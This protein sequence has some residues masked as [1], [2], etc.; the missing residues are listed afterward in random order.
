VTALYGSIQVAA[1]GIFAAVSNISSSFEDI[2][3]QFR[4]IAPAINKTLVLRNEMLK[5]Y[6]AAGINLQKVIVQSV[7]FNMSLAKTK[8]AFDA[9]YKSVGAKFIPTLTKQMDIFRQK[10]YQNMPNIQAALEK[11]VFFL[12]KA[13]DATVQLGSRVWSILQR[14]YDFFYDLHRRTDGWSTVII[15]IIAAWK[16]LNLSFLNTPIGRIIALGLAI[17]ALYDDFMTFKEGGE[18]LI[19]WGSDTTKMIVGLVASIVSVAGAVYAVITA[20]KAINGTVG[21]VKD[22]FSTVKTVIDGA[23]TAWAAFNFVLALNP[24]TLWIVAATVLLGLIG[25]LIW[26]WDLVKKSVLGFFSGLGDKM[27]NLIGAAPSLIQNLQNNPIASVVPLGSNV[28]N[29]PQTNQNV[30]QQT[31]INV[32]GVSDAQSVGKMV[33]GEQSRVNFDMVR[34]L[35]GATR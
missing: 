6:G 10:I 29:S 22:T 18:S 24:L 32:N 26:K 30:N 35:T 9:I 23:K 27:L 34:N 31:N 11:F 13:F 3:Y 4:I 8:F 5:A 28:A 16:L 12:L 14:I 21:I 1:A 20:I 25:L 7:K 15:G 2:G 17:V 19:D 33:A